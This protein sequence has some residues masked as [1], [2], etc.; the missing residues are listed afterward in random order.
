[1]MEKP[2]KMVEKQW[3]NNGKMME[4]P[5]KMMEEPWKNDGRTMGKM[6]ETT[7]VMWNMLKYGWN[8]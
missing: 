3:K 1:M 6:M 7:L 5:W 8:G 2:W 4:K